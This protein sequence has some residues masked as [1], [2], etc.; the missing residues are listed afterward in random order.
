MSIFPSG[1]L[2][3]S[4]SFTAKLPGLLSS[5][6]KFAHYIEM[7][8]CMC[9]ITVTLLID[10][11]SLLIR[12]R[13]KTFIQSWAAILHWPFRWFFGFLCGLAWRESQYSPGWNVQNYPICKE[14]L[15]S[16]WKQSS[17][18]LR[19]KKKKKVFLNKHFNFCV[20]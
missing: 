4:Y 9:C 14:H 7:L 12:E 16:Y 2:F 18:S 8:Y 11:K 20:Y 17:K 3:D 15:Q 6:E 5:W 19:L 10:I 1:E 13:I